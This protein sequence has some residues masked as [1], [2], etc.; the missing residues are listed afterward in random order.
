MGKTGLVFLGKKFLLTFEAFKIILNI[1][2]STNTSPVFAH[3]RVFVSL[4]LFVVR[5]V[6]TDWDLD[7]KINTCIVIQLVATVLSLYRSYLIEA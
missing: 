3:S 2:M 6:P 7:F 4:T 5:A 1:F